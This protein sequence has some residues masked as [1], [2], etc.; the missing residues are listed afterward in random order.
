MS[1]ISTRPLRDS[2]SSQGGRREEGEEEREEGGEGRKEGEGGGGRGLSLQ[3]RR[4]RLR[5]FVPGHVVRE[6]AWV[7]AT[8]Y[9]GLLRL[10]WSC[11]LLSLNSG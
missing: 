4:L 7:R 8:V 5:Q 10:C 2:P 1:A 9:S 3:R 11:S 6:Q